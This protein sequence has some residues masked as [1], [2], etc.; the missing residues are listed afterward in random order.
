MPVSEDHTKFPLCFQLLIFGKIAG[1]RDHT[2]SRLRRHD[3]SRFEVPRKVMRRGL[4]KEDHRE[5]SPYNM[6]MFELSDGEK[7]RDNRSLMRWCAREASDPGPLSKARRLP[8]LILG[9][10]F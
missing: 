5:T 4:K 8:I 10:F 9:S 1:C 2:S 7:D 3:V 6:S